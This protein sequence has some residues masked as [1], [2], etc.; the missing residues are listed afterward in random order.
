MI[1]TS[2]DEIAKISKLRKVLENI[3]SLEEIEKLETVLSFKNNDLYIVIKDNEYYF[4]LSLELENSDQEITLVTNFGELLKI[5]KTYTKKSEI[6]ISIKEN[7]D[8]EGLQDKDV[9]K[10]SI[11]LSKESPKTKPFLDTKL[12]RVNLSSIDLLTGLIACYKLSKKMEVLDIESLIKVSIKNNQISFFANSNNEILKTN[13]DFNDEESSFFLEKDKIRL[14][15]SAIQETKAFSVNL[16]NYKGLILE[17]NNL[18]VW[19]SK[20]EKPGLDLEELV[21]NLENKLNFKDTNVKIDEKAINLRTTEDRIVY[22]NNN[23]LTSDSINTVFSDISKIES[24][25]SDKRIS[26]L[27]KIKSLEIDKVMLGDKDILKLKNDF[28][29]Y[30]MLPQKKTSN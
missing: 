12:N 19:V 14:I 5:V 8:F 17:A 16:I 26:E 29:S 2:K 25:Y 18:L 27:I 9:V 6:S 20:S 22:L 10:E 1:T 13:F 7:I 30:Y 11:I 4:Q 23:D 21:N 24:G 28:L 3:Y 15:Y